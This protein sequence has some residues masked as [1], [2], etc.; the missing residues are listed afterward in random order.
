MFKSVTPPLP[1]SSYLNRGVKSIHDHFGNIKDLANE[2]NK[3]FSEFYQFASKSG[4]ED[5]SEYCRMISDIGNDISK[6]YYTFLNRFEPISTDSNDLVKM[7]VK[8]SEFLDEYQECV[9]NVRKTE[10]R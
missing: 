5:V 7:R 3:F 2:Y 1:D 10:E 4:S 6:S 8:L 9:K